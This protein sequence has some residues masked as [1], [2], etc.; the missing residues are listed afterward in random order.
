MEKLE[1]SVKKYYKQRY[2]LFSK[3]D[4]GIILDTESWF[5]VTPE[6]I[7]QHIAKRVRCN[8]IIDAF[9]GA[10]GNSIQFASICNTVI[11]IDVD[12][13]KIAIAKNNAKVYGVEK[14]ILFV[15]G[16]ALKYLSNPG[17]EADVIFLSPPWG[18]PEYLNQEI[19]DLTT[20]PIDGINLFKLA[21]KVTKN[22]V[23]YLPR[24]TDCEQITSL[25]GRGNICEIEETFL[26]N[27]LKCLTVYYGNLIK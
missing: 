19:F 5:S 13:K 18:G 10:G 7:A 8:V 20:M 9:C 12:P 11:A 24:T 26:N 14:K 21:S 1:N 4:D 22:I 23:Y 6:K 25:A 27:R 15:I 2:S 16:D 17:L 3:F